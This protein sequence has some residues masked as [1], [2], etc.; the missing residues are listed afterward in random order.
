MFGDGHFD[1]IRRPL[2]SRRTLDW[3]EEMMGIFD[4]DEL[5]PLPGMITD[6]E[7]LRTLLASLARTL[8]VG[9][10]ADCFIDPSTALCP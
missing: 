4:R 5:Q 1:Q 10:L 7:R 6:L 8:H 3:R 2:D 9:V